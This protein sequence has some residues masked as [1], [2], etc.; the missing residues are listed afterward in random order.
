MK[1]V[2]NKTILQTQLQKYFFYNLKMMFLKQC[3][4]FMQT[5][6]NSLGNVR[7]RMSF[8]SLDASKKKEDRSE[9]ASP[10]QF[11]PVLS[12][13]TG[14]IW[15]EGHMWEWH[16]KEKPSRTKAVNSVPGQVYFKYCLS[17]CYWQ[18]TIYQSLVNEWQ[19]K[20]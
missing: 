10:F 5:H 4:N 14:L 20:Y 11:L 15:H 13:L 18:I 8:L 9:L 19:E 6:P 12:R 2:F 1:T 7:S 16:N 17:Y 3:F